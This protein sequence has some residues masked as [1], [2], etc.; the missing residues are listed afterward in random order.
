M[1]WI[2]RSEVEELTAIKVFIQAPHKIGFPPTQCDEFLN[3]VYNIERVGPLIA[4]RPPVVWSSPVTTCIASFHEAS[5]IVKDGAGSKCGAIPE[6]VE[7]LRPSQQAGEYGD[8]IIV[9]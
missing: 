7:I 8:R 9:I 1:N 3:G 2:P 5:C 4:F 6:E